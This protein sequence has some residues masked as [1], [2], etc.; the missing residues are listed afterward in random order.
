MGEVHRV[1][2]RGVLLGEIRHAKA[3]PRTGDE[4]MRL[5]NLVVAFFFHNSGGDVEATAENT[6]SKRTVQEPIC[7]EDVPHLIEALW[8]D[9]GGVRLL[10]DHGQLLVDDPLHQE[11]LEHLVVAGSYL[12]YCRDW[13]GW[14][15][16]RSGSPSRKPMGRSITG[17]RL[18]D[19]RTVVMLPDR[20]ANH[21]AKMLGCH[22][23][24]VLSRLAVTE[25]FFGARMLRLFNYGGG[26]R[27]WLPSTYGKEMGLRRNGKADGMVGEALQQGER[28]REC[29]EKIKARRERNE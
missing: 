17:A 24:T 2:A 28:L 11:A 9:L 23:N 19:L 15:A 7:A 4:M 14:G 8:R 29:V 20:N 10:D 1:H 6:N 3:Q 27:W 18:Q 25:H 21:V 5:L 22:P 13:A 12:H 16:S 26:L